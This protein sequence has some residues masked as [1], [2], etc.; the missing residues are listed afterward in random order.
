MKHLGLKTIDTYI[1]R[2]FISTFFYT[3]GLIILIAVIFDLSEKLDDFLDNGISLKQIIFDY[4][5]NFIPYFAVLFSP[6]FTFVSVIYFTSRM[7]A[8]SEII[9]ILSSGISLKRVLL[10]YFIGAFIIALFS[11]TLQNYILPDSRKHLLDFEE[12]YGI[13]SSKRYNTGKDIHQQIEPGVFLYVRTFY[14]G[15]NSASTVTLEKFENNILISKLSAKRMLWDTTI[16]KWTFVDYYIRNINGLEEEIIK[17]KR[18]DTTLNILPNDFKKQVK[19][20]ETMDLKELNV[21]IE[22]QIMQGNDNVI[23][24][25]LEKYKRTSSPF[26]AFVLTIIG[27]TVSMRKTR[28]GTGGHIAIGV[29]ISFAFILFMQFSSQFAIGGSLNPMLAIWLPN[30]I[31][32]FVA[33]FLYI[34][35]PK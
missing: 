13:N 10:P 20:I 33:I 19:I 14:T 6:L 2:K 9:A 4:Y 32:S 16:N 11:F 24:F 31:F 8:N 35:A 25:L 22:E 27:L 15:N 21:F 26:A 28:G 5:F 30:I 1:I 12:E 3:I 29:A 23:S 7:A 18:L 17:G 34:L